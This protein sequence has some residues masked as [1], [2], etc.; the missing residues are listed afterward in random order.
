[1]MLFMLS[2]FGILKFFITPYRH[3]LSQKLIKF[4]KNISGTEIKEDRILN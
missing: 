4:F 1:M 3:L 2:C